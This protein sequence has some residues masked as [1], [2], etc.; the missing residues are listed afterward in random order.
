[1]Q[2][3]RSPAPTFARTRAGGGSAAAG[4]ERRVEQEVSPRSDLELARTRTLQVRMM[5]DA[6]SAQRQVALQ[7]LR[8]LVMDADYAVSDAGMIPPFWLEAPLDDLIGVADEFDPRR[9]RLEAEAAMAGAEAR[10]SAAARFPAVSAQYSY[11]DVYGHRLGVSVR[12][13]ATGLSEL[14]EARAASLRE[15]AAGQRVDVAMQDLRTQVA[16]DYIDYTSAAGRLDVAL[17]SSLSTNGVRDSYMRQFTSGKRG[18]LD[19]MNAMREAMSAQLDVIDIQY[20]AAQ[21][22]TRLVL[23]MGIMP[24]EMERQD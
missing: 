8:A 19:V 11:D 9:K 2:S 20:A 13:Q 18:W 4:M 21:A 16:S 14:G 24:A 6:V 22:Q 12:A 7:R 23:R 3:A 17:A 15:D 1:M 10:A 5:R